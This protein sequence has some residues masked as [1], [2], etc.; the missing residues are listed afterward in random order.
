M[1]EDNSDR[2]DSSTESDNEG[3]ERTVKTVMSPKPGMFISPES[4]LASMYLK[5][6][7]SS[8]SLEGE[9]LAT[10]SDPIISL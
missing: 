5:L 1:E 6:Q 8:Q 10:A 9:T 7:L 2:V 4:Q 3:D